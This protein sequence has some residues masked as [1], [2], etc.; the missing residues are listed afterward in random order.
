M[1]LKHSRLNLSNGRKNYSNGTSTTFSQNPDGLVQQKFSTR[2]SRCKVLYASSCTWNVKKKKRKKKFVKLNFFHR[3]SPS[4]IY[5]TDRNFYVVNETRS[6]IKICINLQMKYTRS[7]VS[8]VNKCHSSV[9]EFGKRELRFSQGNVQV[10]GARNTCNNPRVGGPAGTLILARLN[11]TR[12]Q[13][14]RIFLDGERR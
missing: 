6:F 7:P 4:F 12:L 14:E 11:Y 10:E 5:I 2:L 13:N 8:E 9:N 3:N 1:T